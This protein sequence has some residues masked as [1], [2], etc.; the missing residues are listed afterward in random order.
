[1]SSWI[2]HTDGACSGNPGP[3]GIGVWATDD[4]GAT[5]L[6]LS[7]FIGPGTNNWAEY[8]AIVRGLEEAVAAGVDH[9]EV[10]CDSQVVVR[11]INGEYA[12]RCPHLGAERLAIVSLIGE[13]SRFNISH[14]YDDGNRRADRLAKNAARRG[15][16][17]KQM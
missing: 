1:M 5:A 12:C 15:Y 2:M 6:E 7:E 4:E 17:P 16:N 14:I 3:S 10:F 13:F 8:R 11:Q 9:L